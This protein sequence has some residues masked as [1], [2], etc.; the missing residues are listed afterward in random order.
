[1]QIIEPNEKIML[2]VFS[3]IKPVFLVD[4][5]NKIYSYQ[6][7]NQETNNIQNIGNEIIL[8]TIFLLNPCRRVKC[9]LASQIKSDK[10]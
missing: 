2:R 6:F 8:H 5:K 10:A 7:K 4:I 3:Y 1:M 9:C